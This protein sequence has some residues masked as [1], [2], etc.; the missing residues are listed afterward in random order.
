VV[1][2]VP[3]VVGVQQAALRPSW[4]VVAAV[5]AALLVARVALH[6]S[7]QGEAAAWVAAQLQNKNSRHAVHAAMPAE[8]ILATK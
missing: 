3:R 2:V 5:V 4:L 8:H 1:L 7:S 6:P